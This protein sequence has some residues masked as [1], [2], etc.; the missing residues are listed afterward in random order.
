MAQGTAGSLLT[1]GD[2]SGLVASMGNRYAMSFDTLKHRLDP[3]DNIG[4]L[5]VE[6]LK[7]ISKWLSTRFAGRTDLRM[8]TYRLGNGAR[9][10]VV[11]EHV[12]RQLYGSDFRTNPAALAAAALNVRLV[13]DAAARRPANAPSNANAP[14]PAPAHV[15]TA[16]P[17]PPPLPET[18]PSPSD[19][20][21]APL[22]AH[23]HTRT[24]C[25]HSLIATWKSSSSP[26]APVAF[27]LPPPIT[28]V[29][30]ITKDA[31]EK[32]FDF[33]KPP[34]AQVRSGIV[35]Y[36]HF[37]S[38]AA[39]PSANCYWSFKGI[40]PGASS[41]PLVYAGS[42]YSEKINLTETLRTHASTM[43]RDLLANRPVYLTFSVNFMHRGNIGSM[44]S[45][46]LVQKR[47]GPDERVVALYKSVLGKLP[48]RDVFL[49]PDLVV[50]EPK[51]VAP[52]AQPN[53]NAPSASAP[54]ASALQ[55][56]ATAAKPGANALRLFAVRAS[57]PQAQS[58]SNAAGPSAFALPEP[59]V[60]RSLYVRRKP[61]V[62][63]DS[64]AKSED[65]LIA[66]LFDFEEADSSVMQTGESAVVEKSNSN[67]LVPVS[68]A[69]VA[70]PS[71]DSAKVG[72]VD[73]AAG[74]PSETPKPTPG[75]TLAAVV[76]DMN[77]DGLFKRDV[78]VSEVKE[79]SSDSKSAVV[80]GSASSVL[81]ANP[82]I[83]VESSLQL[84]L[85]EPSK[86][87]FPAAAPAIPAAEAN[88]SVAVKSAF[89]NPDP[90]SSSSSKATVDHQPPNAPR[91]NDS[92]LKTLV[93]LI[94]ATHP[95]P[96]PAS[97]PVPI[98]PL[99]WKSS[100]DTS[101]LQTLV[102]ESCARAPHASTST[103]A[104][105]PSND[106]ICVGDSVV[107]FTCPL[108]LKRVQ[109]PAR[110]KNC[111]H[112]QA[113]DAKIFLAFN[114]NKDSWKCIVCN[115]HIDQSDLLL[116]TDMLRLL[117][118]YP[119][120]DKC[121]IKSTGEDTPFTDP[122]STSTPTPSQSTPQPRRSTSILNIDATPPKRTFSEVIVIDSDS[123]SE[124]PLSKRR[125]FSPVKPAAGVVVDDGAVEYVT[126][127]TVL[128]SGKVVETI[129]ID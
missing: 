35:V 60:E 75:G 23:V 5:T 69:I 57:A 46:I 74:S 40:G 39:L 108:S 100:N 24:A 2:I 67:L 8:P 37:Y 68:E 128:E 11:V 61:D 81:V 30:P 105:A 92:P 29:F 51:A 55:A 10:Q 59:V 4:H 101:M 103:S 76:T 121:I 45:A 34:S 99:D 104:N 3:V 36:W 7:G 86:V 54:N 85:I 25:S 41:I 58:N 56:Q 91:T 110:G 111:K 32:V 19:A 28:L 50:P 82:S 42:I 84:S 62:D 80:L 12:Q 93:E 33:S 44:Q 31:L 21:I 109:H 49:G 90:S 79:P 95:T 126:E 124:E 98:P 17:A 64:Y 78:V 114:E 22:L 89:P 15:P 48:A 106:D 6:Q 52:Q 120:A 63:M 71:L 88:P 65:E 107:S 20:E 43:H 83:A 112:K 27:G 129:V 9:K 53:T 66:L 47:L 102:L 123:D 115:H 70:L 125:A 18:T 77:V 1:A 113:F 127:R 72:A 14:R 94:N 16:A 26:A 38:V 118:K 13:C 96:I 117:H 73:T 122:T 97:P 116:D 119:T 87:A